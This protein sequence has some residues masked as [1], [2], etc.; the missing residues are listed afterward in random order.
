MKKLLFLLMTATTLMIFTSSCHKDNDRLEDQELIDQIATST[1]KV[2]VEPNDLPTLV[3]TEIDE[4]YFETFI[5][6]SFLA[7][8]LGYE[9]Q[10]GN[11]ERLYFGTDGV[12]LR[13]RR[14]PHHGHGP[15][16]F[17]RRGTPVP[18]ADLSATIT[19]YI[20]DNYTNPEIK[21]AKTNDEGYFFVLVKTDDGRL[22]VKFDADGNYVGEIYLTHHLCLGI[23]PVLVADLPTAITDYLADNCPDGVIMRAGKRIISGKYIVVLNVNGDRKVVVFDADGNFLFQRD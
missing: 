15:C 5:E 21:R 16:G 12:E 7:R 1:D 10:L 14:G 8:D 4:K 23:V 19:D 22:V 9:V 2:T 11:G 20:N 13:S 17:G 6:S 3:S 18:V